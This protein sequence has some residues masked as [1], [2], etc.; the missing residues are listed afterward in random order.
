MV[1]TRA[2]CTIFDVN[3]P[4]PFPFQASK[5]AL[6]PKTRLWH[7]TREIPSREVL[8]GPTSSTS[9]DAMPAKT[10]TGSAPGR[11]LRSLRAEQISDLV[12]AYGD[13]SREGT[14]ARA[15]FSETISVCFL[16]KDGYFVT[17]HS[18]MSS[19]QRNIKLPGR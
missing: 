12:F 13:H 5:S 1:T 9:W 18:M 10:V 17:T 6:C 3:C 19:V 15:A 11:S 14:M 2:L 7:R 16:K 8:S 4:L